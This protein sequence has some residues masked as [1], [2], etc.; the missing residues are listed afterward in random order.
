MEEMVCAEN[1]A[2]YFNYEIVPLRQPDK[3]DFCVRRSMLF[4]DSL[5]CPVLATNGRLV[6]EHFPMWRETGR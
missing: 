4:S 2:G 3:P 5:E 1:N 6:F